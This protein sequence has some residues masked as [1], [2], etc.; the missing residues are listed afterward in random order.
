MTG[1]QTKVADIK[2]CRTTALI[3]LSIGPHEH[4]STAIMKVQQ[5]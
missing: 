1:N 3:V 5:I 4:K 2:P